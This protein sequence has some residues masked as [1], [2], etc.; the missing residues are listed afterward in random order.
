MPTLAGVQSEFA[1]VHLDRLA[2]VPRVLRIAR[3]EPR[4]A[5]HRRK[6]TA[7]FV[8]ELATRYP[9]VKRLVG[10]EFFRDLAHAY[11]SADQ[12][13][14]PGIWCHDARFP[15]F[16][17]WFA[18]AR[19]I[20]YLGAIAR[21]ELAR[22]LAGRTAEA[23]SLRAE[24]FTGLPRHQLAQSRVTLHPSV[25][26][27]SSPFPIYSIWKVNQTRAAVVP[28]APWAAEAVLVA[29]S[30]GAAQVHK[31]A[32]GQ[33]AFLTALNKGMMLADAIDAGFAEAAGFD[34]ASALALLRT[35]K[36]VVRLG[37]LGNLEHAR[38]AI[39]HAARPREI[40]GGEHYPRAA[41]VPI[42]RWK[43]ES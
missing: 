43:G 10:K 34:V 28:V 31:L 11:V 29:R 20:P 27:V 33:A 13:R 30:A 4:V 36:L 35:A 39:L 32:P 38:N 17:D 23:D 6:I 18:P 12:P 37:G 7:D 8:L 24:D 5:I 9:A 25:S 21:I 2:P 15:D 3:R 14:A 19:P 16:I 1:T 40:P 42:S 26:I 22:G 41:R